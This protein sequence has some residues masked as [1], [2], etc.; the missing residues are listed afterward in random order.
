MEEVR[1]V[2]HIEHPHEADAPGVA[3]DGIVLIDQH[4]HAT[5]DAERDLGVA[6]RSED[7]AGSGVRVEELDLIRRELEAGVVLEQVGRVVGE[8]G[9]LGARLPSLTPGESEETE[10]E[11]AVHS[12]EEWLAV[13]EVVETRQTAL[14]NEVLEEVLRGGIRGDAGRQHQPHPPIPGHQTPRRL[15]KDRVG[16]DVAPAGKWVAARVAH[17]VGLAARSAQRS[18]ILC[19]ETR[20]RTF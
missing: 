14:L 11:P 5:V 2:G 15:G 4:R 18:K 7:W 10:L 13:L 8:E 12:F 16:V 20:V 1:V 17:Q 19:V 9:E 3:V 6:T